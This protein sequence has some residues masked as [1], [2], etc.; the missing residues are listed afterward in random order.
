MVTAMCASYQEDAILPLVRNVISI[1]YDDLPAEAIG[2][3]KKCI[4]DTLGVTMAGSTAQGC[5]TI[6]SMV[7]EWGGRQESTIL[8]YGE[9]VPSPNAAW[10]NATMARARDLDDYDSVTAEHPSVSTVTTALA[11][12]ELVGGVTGKEAITAIILGDDLSIRIRS[13]F[14][15]KAG[16]SPWV[17]SSFSVFPSAA[18]AGKLLGLDEDQMINAM[19]L[20]FCQVSNTLQGHQEGALAVRVHHGIGV[21]A[22][23]LSAL[24]ARRGITGPHHVLEG[25]FGLYPIYGQNEYDRSLA[26]AELGRRF[27]NTR[28]STKPWPCCGATYGVVEGALQLVQEY[29]IHPEDVEE[30]TVYIDQ[31]AYAY[32][33]EPEQ[34]KKRPRTVP[35]AQF[36]IP[37]A[38]GAAV[39]YR[40]VTLDNFTD[41]SIKDERVL[42]IARKVNAVIKPELTAT[43]SAQ[44]P[45]L[46]EIRTKRGKVGPRRIDYVRGSPQNPMTLEECIE[47]FRKCLNFSVKPLPKENTEEVINMVKGLEDVSNIARIAC[48]LA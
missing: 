39:V 27:L 32:T 40:D 37:Y 12:S 38:L 30:I 26:L 6:A 47:K 42:K 31:T 29:D 17:S 3:A 9:Q 43:P 14:K 23:L 13:A 20:A 11:V 33:F 36:S 19:G 10:V 46:V 24:M 1:R 22:G 16:M 7:K 18:V 45:S 8:A 2:A 4:I 15:V 5:D 41:E 21:R 48:L 28:M 44:A 34:E 25:R 35:A